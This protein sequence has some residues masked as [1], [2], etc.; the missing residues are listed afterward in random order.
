MSRFPDSEKLPRPARRKKRRGKPATQEERAALRFEAIKLRFPWSNEEYGELWLPW[1]R[2]A[3]CNL[4]ADDADLKEI[5]RGFVQ[6]GEVTNIL[7]GLTR[8]KKHLE[9]MT[10]TVDAALMRT[11]VVLERLGYSPENPP[12]DS[13][14]N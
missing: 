1:I 12:P 10:A 7:E 13:R 2:L 6:D 8:T 11:F 9:Q 5:M 3:L 4:A 14:L